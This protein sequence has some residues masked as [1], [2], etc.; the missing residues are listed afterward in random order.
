MIR[1]QTTLPPS[2]KTTNRATLTQSVS[3]PTVSVKISKSTTVRNLE[4]VIDRPEA[5]TAPAAAATIRAHSNVAVA[6]A[7]ATATT[8]AAATATA[9]P[10][11]AATAAE[12][13]HRTDLSQKFAPSTHSTETKLEVVAR[14][15]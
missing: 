10:T 1:S 8:A 3:V 4:V 13:R 14:A 7:A 2:T 15:V 6:A 12:T 9:T 5:A 11:E